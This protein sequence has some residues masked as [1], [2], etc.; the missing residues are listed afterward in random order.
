MDTSSLPLAFGPPLT[1]RHQLPSSSL[2]MSLNVAK[3]H[4]GKV[5][6]ERVGQRSPPS[7]YVTF[8]AALRALLTLVFF[9]AFV[10]FAVLLCLL[11]VADHFRISLLAD[12]LGSFL[13]L[14][15]VSRSLSTLPPGGRRGEQGLGICQVSIFLGKYLH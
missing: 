8:G 4:L 7:Q 15:T 9:A 3:Y 6:P 1:F 5:K 11:I 13:L 2:A 10:A 14:A 12:R